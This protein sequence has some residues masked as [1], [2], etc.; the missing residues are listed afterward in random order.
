MIPS[1]RAGV[2][3]LVRMGSLAVAAV[4]LGACWGFFGGH[5]RW[6]GSDSYEQLARHLADGQGYSVD[7]VNPTALRP[8]L[9]PLI[10]A[11]TMRATAGGWFLATVLLQALVAA[12]CLMLVFALARACW[13]G[14]RAPWL[15]AGLLALHGPFMFEMLSLRETAW[16][17]LALLGVAWLL[18]H[19]PRTAAHAVALGVLLASLYL[20]RPTGLVVGGVTLAFLGWSVVQ[21]QSGAGRTLA[22][23]LAAGVAVVAPWQAFTWRNFGA[24]GFFPASSNGYNLFKGADPEITRVLPWIDA[25]TLD[26]RLAPL[27]GNIPATDERAI[28]REFRRRAIGLIRE[29]PAAMIG[30]LALSAG[31]FLSPLPIPLGTGAFRAAG[32]GIVIDDFRLDWPEVAFAPVVAALLVSACGGLRPLWRRQGDPGGLGL[33]MVIV[34]ASFLAIHALTFTKTRYRLPLDALLAIP[35]GGWLAGVKRRVPPTDAR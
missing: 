2:P 19:R 29:K 28:D 34:F 30:R 31:E 6:P 33:W 12:L 27:A 22:I 20:L 23:V 17:T 16:F 3:R 10:L 24:P 1:P 32:G 35:A 9:Y 15:A 14:S 4:Y 26:A 18:R 5:A 8:P 21:R 11:A 25:D 13:P 7:G